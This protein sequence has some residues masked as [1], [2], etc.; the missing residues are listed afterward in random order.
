[1][2]EI[3]KEFGF[4]GTVKCK[5]DD[6]EHVEMIMFTAI[7]RIQQIIPELTALDITMMLNS[8]TGRHLADELLDIPGEITPALILMR[9]AMWNKLSVKKWL[10]HYNELALVLPT[11]D[12]R[13][14]YVSAIKN[15]MKKKSIRKLMIEEI[16]CDENSAWPEPETWINAE[17]VPTKELEMMWLYIQQKLQTKGKK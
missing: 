10:M 7:R 8:R 6:P 12:K 5:F 3:N 4:Y 14:L 17:N 2:T 1:M 16:G 13:M 9:I 15:E 11:I